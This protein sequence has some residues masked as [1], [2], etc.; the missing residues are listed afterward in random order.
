MTGKAD[1]TDA[2]DHC[3]FLSGEDTGCL[4][5]DNDLRRRS[6]VICRICPIRFSFPPPGSPLLVAAKHRVRS[7]S[8]QPP[9]RLPHNSVRRTHS[10]SFV[11]HSAVPTGRSPWALSVGMNPFD[12]QRGR[13][14]ERSSSAGASRGRRPSPRGLRRC[15]GLR[16]G[17]PSGRRRSVPAACQRRC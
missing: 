5:A 13:L 7:R 6:A 10:S 12:P 16:G 15:G 9:E 8:L 2:A 3:G 4:S 14:N 11:T 17:S 1:Q